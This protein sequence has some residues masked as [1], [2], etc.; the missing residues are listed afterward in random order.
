[1]SSDV[2]RVSDLSPRGT[3]SIPG[4]QRRRPHFRL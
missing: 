1:M 2:G 4:P 3:G